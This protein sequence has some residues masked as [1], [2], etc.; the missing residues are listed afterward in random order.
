MDPAQH[1]EQEL[2]HRLYAPMPAYLL[3]LISMTLVVGCLIQPSLVEAAVRVSR[4]Y[5]EDFVAETTFEKL[6]HR[7]S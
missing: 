7:L 5:L 4:E 1:F 6:Y 2:E 3:H